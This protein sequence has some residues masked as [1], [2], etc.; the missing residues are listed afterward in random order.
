MPR[1]LLLLSILMWFS[2]MYARA[3]QPIV[4]NE[5]SGWPYT[6]DHEWTI[7]IQGSYYGLRQCSSRFPHG[8][9]DVDTHI[10]VAGKTFS[11]STHAYVALI[12]LFVLFFVMLWLCR[13]ATVRIYQ[14]IN[15]MRCAAP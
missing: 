6:I 12:G 4:I 14:R 2:P 10:F 5:E 8:F 7:R 11:I 1:L 9:F 13:L 3:E 15:E